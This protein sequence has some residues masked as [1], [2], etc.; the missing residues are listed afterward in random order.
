[1]R[2]TACALAGC[3][4]LALAVGCGESSK[5]SASASTTQAAGGQ[6]AAGV[7]GS[8]G[9]PGGATR[10]GGKKT[11]A[12]SSLKYDSTPKFVA[13]SSSAP[14]QSGVVQ[15]AYR[16][17]AINPDTVRV[18]VGTTVRWTNYDSVAHNVTS[19]GGPIKFA[20]KNFGEGKTFEVKMTKPGIVH[21]ECTL[22]P[23]TMNGTIEVL[24]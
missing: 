17:I 11:P 18:K 2:P 4:A 16:N 14:V 10:P 7:S 5:P 19:E 3:I 24:S 8:A 13:P 20:S 21:Y 15:I 23:V 12:A 9:T 1:M 6:G 22:Q